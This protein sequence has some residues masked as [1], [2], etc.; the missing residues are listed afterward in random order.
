MGQ[1]H[2]ENLHKACHRSGDQAENVD[3]V[4][5]EPVIEGQADGPTDD[6]RGGQ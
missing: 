4:L 3:P 5:V 6:Y 1:N 2:T